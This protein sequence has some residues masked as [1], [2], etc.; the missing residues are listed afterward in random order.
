LLRKSIQSTKAGFWD[1]LL[2]REAPDGKAEIA[3]GHHRLAALKAEYPLEHQADLIIKP[4]DNADMLKIMANENMEEWGSD[5]VAEHES[6]RAVVVAYAEGKIE[7]EQPAS[8]KDVR[9]AP[10][11]I[12]KEPDPRTS[13]RPKEANPQH[14]GFGFDRAYNAS[15]VANF[16]GWTKPPR[17]TGDRTGRADPEQRV[18]DGLAALQLIEEGI[19]PEDGFHGLSR[20]QARI[21]IEEVRITR[22]RQGLEAAVEVAKGLAQA[23]K[24]GGLSAHA[25]AEIAPIL[26]YPD[27]EERFHARELKFDEAYRQ[28]RERDKAAAG[29]GEE[30]DRVEEPED[31]E[32]RSEY[33]RR[34]AEK[35]KHIAELEDADG[36]PNGT[37]D[38]I[39]LEFKKDAQSEDA[40]DSDDEVAADQKDPRPVQSGD[41]DSSSGDRLDLDDFD[42]PNWDDFG[43]VKIEPAPSDPLA[44]PSFSRIHQQPDMLISLPRLYSFQAEIAAWTWNP[45]TSSG[46]DGAPVFHPERLEAPATSQLPED[47]ASDPCAR[48]VWVCP[49]FDLYG[50]DVPGEWI[51]QVHEACG[52]NPQWEYSFLTK[53]PA[54]YRAIGNLPPTAWLGALVDSWPTV[55]AAEQAFEKITSV[56]VKWVLIQP[57]LNDLNFD[58]PCVNWVVVGARPETRGPAAIAEEAFTPAFEA[59]AEIITGARQAQRP[60]FCQQN[61]LGI[62]SGAFPGM[63]LP[64]EMPPTH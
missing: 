18:I 5:V 24:T 23:M 35:E 51:A 59:V 64:K 27:L 33:R 38:G 16:L 48:R 61:L 42:D 9:L 12:P 62:T 36:D 31:D 28:A 3:Y 55:R 43:L 50:P 20:T 11:F 47:L 45:V 37:D 13:T 8:M 21:L 53:F 17:S 40:E 25:A 19:L 15:T 10:S 41:D 30:G 1:N 14:L 63:R 56:L 32:F 34:F 58:Y 52:K 44:R 46:P 2:A 60:V 57:L 39:D 22:K 49:N 4:L 29:Q 7:L 26:R 6:I 54:R